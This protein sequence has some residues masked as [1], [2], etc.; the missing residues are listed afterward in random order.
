V[1]GSQVTVRPRRLVW[2]GGVETYSFAVR[3]TPEP[4]KELKVEGTMRQGPLVPGTVAMLALVAI[5]AVAAGGVLV[6]RGA[7]PTGAISRATPSPSNAVADAAL[8][9]GQGAPSASPSA[10]ASASASPGAPGAAKSPSPG[11][12]ASGAAAAAGGS[13]QATAAPTPDNLPWPSPPDCTTYNPS[14]LTL[15]YD[16]VVSKWVV[17]ESG[18]PNSLLNFMYQAD[19]GDGLALAKRYTQLCFIGRGN[20]Y[21]VTHWSYILKYWRGPTGTATAIAT[22]DCVAYNRPGLT[23]VPV[24][25]NDYEVTDGTI[26]LQQFASQADAG[27]GVTVLEH[28]TNMCYIG[29]DEPLNAPNRASRLTEYYS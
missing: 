11:P 24:S 13:G 2:F 10:S 18:N 9:I 12:S 7:L 29:R 26:V 19:G 4:G 8:P 22:R 17:E 14:A 1:A 21:T 16:N 5:I 25:S 3:A 23:V 20:T 6:G 27:A 28:S 15:S